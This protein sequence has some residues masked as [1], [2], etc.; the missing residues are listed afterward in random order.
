MF[1]F[2]NKTIEEFRN[3]VLGFL[4]KEITLQDGQKRILDKVTECSE[5]YI[6]TMTGEFAFQKNGEFDWDKGV[7]GVKMYGFC[8]EIS[9]YPDRLGY[10]TTM[11][12][13]I[14]VPFERRNEKQYLVIMSDDSIL[15]KNVS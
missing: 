1:E 5:V 14:L 12:E 2:K 8:V 7:S 9:S 3:E 15:S 4:G 10:V 11:P 6:G 13:R